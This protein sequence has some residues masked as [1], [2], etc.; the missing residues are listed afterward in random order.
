M[1]EPACAGAKSRLGQRDHLALNL[2]AMAALSALFPLLGWAF[3][4]PLLT[5]FGI[6]DFP[7]WPLTSLGYLFIASALALIIAGRSLLAMWAMLVPLVI[8]TVTIGEHLLGRSLGFDDLLFGDQVRLVDAIYPGRPGANPVLAFLMLIAAFLLSRRIGAV[9]MELA[10]LLASVALCAGLYSIAM[11]FPIKGALEPYRV[12]VTP[13]PGSIATVTLATAFL[14]WRNKRDWALLLETA[15]VSRPMLWLGIPAA[16]I[17]P[18]LPFLLEQWIARE[19]DPIAS[20]GGMAAVLLNATIIGLLLVVVMRRMR[21]QFAAQRDLTDALDS[22]AIALAR[23]DGRLVH[24]SRGCEELYG[25]PASAALG[26][27]KHAWLDAHR[28]TDGT[29]VDLPLD[30]G[31]DELIEQRRDGSMIHVLERRRLL[32]R[33]GEEPIIVLKLLDISE[34][35]HMENEL[36]L[37]EERLRLAAEVNAIG[38]FEWDVTTGAIVWSPGSEQ[39]LGVAPGM[40]G[41]FESWGR[42]I[43]ADDMAAVM[44][45]IEA[46]AAEQKERFSFKYR[47]NPPAEA[48]RMIE[49]TSHCF[50][51]A[52]GTLLRTIGSVVD[53][54]QR[55]AREAE[56]RLQSIIETVPDATI[57]ID[58]RGLIRSFSE[59]AE[60]TFGWTA[61]QAIGQNVK[62][63]MPS[64]IAASHDRFLSDY[65]VTGDRKVIGRTRELT[66]RRAD[67]SW[68]P[69]ELNV[70]EAQIGDERIFTGIVR[71]VSERQASEKRM[72][73]LH[74]ELAHVSRQSAMSELAADL[75][76]ELNQ[77]LAATANFL[78]AT[79]MLVESGQQ[80]ERVGHL[81]QLAEEQ[82][83][84]SG[85]II[86]RLRDFLAKREVEM[87]RGSLEEVARGAVELVL[88]GA[89]QF[90]VELSYAIADGAG[91]IFADRIQ[92]Q[93][94]FVNL[95]R[96]SVEALRTMPPGHPRTIQIS[97]QRAEEEGMIEVTLCDTGPGLPQEVSE[98]LY[99]R[100][101]TTKSGTAMGIGLSITRRIIE[102]HGGQ[103]EAG[104][105]ENGGAMFR[106]TLPMVEE[107]DDDA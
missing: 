95:L 4:I 13:L 21:S 40:L 7:I 39:R 3:R 17:L 96:N 49:G 23:P 48:P 92:L 9:A 57:V 58:E 104:N 37:S 69:I 5:T 87:R 82:T 89:M 86:R 34:R 42:N 45:T 101:A 51:D 15:K 26:R 97:A 50:Y 19:G 67:G 105:G 84:R 60:A 28:A 1:P 93:Q 90:D 103:L 27:S 32:E 63:L 18:A 33:P 94:V 62:M 10:N 14:W 98:Q 61:E 68:F 73:D 85:E 72:S 11:L 74:A 91:E 22:A 76:H 30:S 80:G 6:A 35:A 25:W 99:E 65:L 107:V 41:S 12:F 56:L 70:G 77:P 36:R 100:F 44:G 78:A 71:D 24:W 88:F 2:T 43:S 79:R 29:V 59:A 66:A 81:L 8:A 53:V 75:A 46:T 83:W 54:T 20:G 106:F 64:G 38:V 47:F 52:S 31:E 16:V 102:A 55:D